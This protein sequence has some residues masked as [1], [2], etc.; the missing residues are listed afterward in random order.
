MG[1]SLDQ[2]VTKLE[3][4]QL[5]AMASTIKQVSQLLNTPNTK[6]SDFQQ[7]IIRDPGF[8]LTLFRLF[9]SNK[10]APREA[11]STLS[12][13]VALLGQGCLKEICR[14]TP[15][16]ETTPRAP[17]RQGLHNGYSQAAHAANYALSLGETIRDRNPVE[18][19]IAAL[20]HELAEMLLWTHAREKMRRIDALKKRGINTESAALSVLNLNLNQLS[21]ALAEQWKLPLLTIDAL[22]PYGA[23]QIRSLG[24]MLCAKLA[25][26]SGRSWAS[27]ATQDLIELMADYQAMDI[28]TTRSALHCASINAARQLSDLPYSLSAYGLIEHP[29]Q[30]NQ[31]MGKRK[32][33]VKNQALE[34]AANRKPA[35]VKADSAVRRKPQSRSTKNIKDEHLQKKLLPELKRIVADLEV[36]QILYASIA[37]DRATMQVKI[38]VGATKQSTLRKFK[39]SLKEKNIFSLIMKKPQDFWVNEKN[40]AKCDPHI[41]NYLRPIIG[42]SFIASSIYIKGKPVGLIYC[43]KG[44]D[45]INSPKTFT[46]YQSIVRG[47]NDQLDSIV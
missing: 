14:T 32:T 26:E 13:I 42:N 2:W 11:P 46:Q 25:N 7:V 24:V 29:I 16:L 36:T 5:P 23:F 3:T 37:S 40:H 44:K 19:A 35:A 10:F 39:F 20:F 12:H 27:E 4:L 9:N 28:D 8:T 47:L 45:L 22:E 15:V 6:N 34:T 43:D 41:P 1:K 30:A 18:L 38:L 17:F 33:E 31:Q 21:Q